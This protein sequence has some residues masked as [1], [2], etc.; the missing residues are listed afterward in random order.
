MSNNSFHNTIAKSKVLP[1]AIAIL[2]FIV[3]SGFYTMAYFA[4]SEQCIDEKCISRNDLLWDNATMSGSPVVSHRIVTESNLFA[5]IIEHVQ[6]GQS[7]I[8]IFC[9]MLATFIGIYILL[10]TLKISPASAIVGAISFGIF[11]YGIAELQAGEFAEMIAVCM[12]PY[13]LSGIVLAF[14]RHKL[15]GASTILIASALQVATSHYQ[16]VYYTLFMAL[17]YVIFALASKQTPTKGKIAGLAL[18]I[19]SIGIAI[20]THSETIFQE[21]EYQRYAEKPVP[22]YNI[23]EAY[24]DDGGE[25]L[26]LLAANIKGSKSNAQLT[27][28][29]ETYNLLS[30]YFGQANAEKIADKSPLYFG[31]KFFSNGPS[32]IGALTIFLALFGGI[33][34]RNKT[35][36]W[37]IA[38]AAIS[39]ILSCGNIEYFITKNIPLFYNFSTFSNIL[40]VA[41][42]GI[43]ILA[44]IGTEELILDTKATAT[45]K[46]ISAYVSAGIPAIILLIFVAFPG[47]AG[48][49]S[50]DTENSAEIDVAKHLAS[51]M[52]QGIEYAEATAEFQNDYINAIRE[53]RLS[54]VRRDAAKSLIFIM[55]GAIIVSVTI[56]KKINGKI[57]VATLAVLTIADITLANISIATANDGDKSQPTNTARDVIK[58]DND[59][60]RVVDISY[61]LIQNDNT[62]CTKYNSLGGDGYSLKRY[63][64]F[65]D[66]ILNKEL[67]LT[68][69]NI[70]SWAQRDG[71]TADEIQQV[72][73]EKYKTPMLDM[74]NVKYIILSERALPL[75]NDHV[76]GNA[77]LVD[78]IQWADSEILEIARLQHI[79]TKT[80]TIVNEKYQHEFADVEFAID[81][82]DFIRL[83]SQKGDTLLY[84]SSCKGNRLA[85][86]S[87]IFYPKGWKAYIDGQKTSFFR[88]N[89]VLRGMI[90]PQGEH[91]IEFRYEPVTATT[92]RIVSTTCNLSLFSIVAIICT[93]GII[94]LARRKNLKH[95]AV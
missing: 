79:D 41:A 26:S 1:H 74:L 19:V 62:T 60:F 47:I 75:K 3:I 42:L 17:A 73:S 21:L 49:C 11:T 10:N 87:E 90:V 35:K 56:R 81:S 89:Y 7:S 25:T 53:D 29:S 27:S 61:D 45:R 31:K 48:D 63:G 33:C 78:S 9:I 95:T 93:L 66:S 85:V 83:A 23:S 50:I 76:S 37:I 68:R 77:W 92:G 40:I 16:I 91:E 28:K 24:F 58:A 6:N 51:Y 39:I 70:L 80:T 82:T 94:R 65:C 36:W 46:R 20:F 22:N 30:P 12:M 57:V 34:S 72:F 84:K 64:T 67:A 55:L 32:Y 59:E 13:I 54:L 44:A 52:P 88:C 15:A 18:T 86:F 69:Y 71:M 43:S 38:T 14:N 5:G 2:I 4:N 8:A